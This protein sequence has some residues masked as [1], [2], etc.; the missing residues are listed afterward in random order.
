MWH[1]LLNGAGTG[2]WLGRPPKVLQ[3]YCPMPRGSVQGTIETWREN[4]GKS[5]A[6]SSLK[7]RRAAE[8]R[9]R[10]K[11]LLSRQ[12]F[13]SYAPYP[14][15]SS[16]FLSL[17]PKLSIPPQISFVFSKHK[18]FVWGF[19]QEHKCTFTLTLQNILKLSASMYSVIFFSREILGR[20]PKLVKTCF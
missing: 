16:S 8:T 20:R 18:L 10:R 6:Q 1:P 2:K 3:S 9:G 12:L 15:P 19:I 5:A 13:F 11:V 17:I 7:H 14:K 4:W